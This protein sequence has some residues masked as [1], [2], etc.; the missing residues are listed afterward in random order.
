MLFRKATPSTGITVTYGSVVALNDVTA[1]VRDRELTAVIGNGSAG[2][3]TF[4]RCL[5]GLESPGSRPDRN[6]ILVT[7]TQSLPPGRTVAEC[8]PG[9]DDPAWRE[10]V[11]AIAGLDGEQ[12]RTAGSLDETDRRSLEIAR[13]LCTRPGLLAVDLPGSP[14]LFALLARYVRELG[15]TIVFAAREAAAARPADRAILLDLGDQVGDLARP[16]PRAV[17]R[18]LE[19]ASRTPSVSWMKAPVMMP[20]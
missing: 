15:C 5:A 11:L 7:G 9:T 14:E 18:R 10:R 1:D 6:T 4:L 3:S 17:A 19:R 8:L 16:T 20:T 12:D 13:A 2:K